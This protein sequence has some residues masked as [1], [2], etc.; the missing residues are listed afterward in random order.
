MD[1]RIYLE[2]CNAP[3]STDPCV[4]AIVAKNPGS[5][6]S[7][8]MG[9][10]APLSLNGDNMLP[11]I[12]NRFRAA[13]ALSGKPIPETGFVRVW[14]LFYL[15]AANLRQAIKACAA[16]TSPPFCTSESLLPPIVWFAWGKSDKYLDPLKVR[17]Q[18]LQLQ[19]AFFFD[20]RQGKVV[21]RI[22]Q[23]DDFAKHPQGMPGSPVVQ[24]LKNHL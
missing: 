10:L 12:R 13:Y 3:A 16:I 4:G 22:P 23:N 15:C 9:Q 5:A 7:E 8:T 24:F 19:R 11:S 21:A 14:N 20:N 1:T 18:R 6:T 17:F 2:N